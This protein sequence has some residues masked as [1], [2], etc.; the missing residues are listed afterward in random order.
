MRNDQDWLDI[1][2]HYFPEGMAAMEVMMTQIF[3]GMSE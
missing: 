2:S 3:M 1:L